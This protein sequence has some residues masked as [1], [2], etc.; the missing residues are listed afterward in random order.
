MKH[1]KLTNHPNSGKSAHSQPAISQLKQY[2]YSLWSTQ[3]LKAKT[4]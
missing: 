1:Y 2:G 3:K 4:N